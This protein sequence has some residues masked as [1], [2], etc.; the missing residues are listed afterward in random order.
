MVPASVTTTTTVTDTAAAVSISVALNISHYPTIVK[1]L[2][3]NLN[4]DDDSYRR[5]RDVDFCGTEH[6]PLP[7]CCRT[8][9]NSNGASKCDDDN[10]GYRH[11]CRGVDFCG[12]EHLPLPYHCQTPHTQLK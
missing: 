5:C 4:D 10:N 11:C 6:L 2:T 8:V 9:C 12:T 3:R 7:Y 1:H